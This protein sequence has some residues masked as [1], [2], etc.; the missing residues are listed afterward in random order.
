MGFHCFSML[1]LTEKRESQLAQ[2]QLTILVYLSSFYKPRYT[3]YI[4]ATLLSFLN[5]GELTKINIEWRN[6][7][8]G[9]VLFVQAHQ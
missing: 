7:I 8:L 5:A 1:R 9:I 4:Q 2:I 6:R 3:K